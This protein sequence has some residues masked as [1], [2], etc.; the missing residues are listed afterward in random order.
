MKIFRIIG[1]QPY[2][3]QYHLLDGNGN[4]IDSHFSSSFDWAKR[5]MVGLKD[6]KNYE[7]VYGEFRVEILVEDTSKYDDL[8]KK[9]IK[10]RGCQQE[11]SEY[12]TD[13][14]KKHTPALNSP[15]II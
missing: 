10:K 1:S 15:L 14:L 9:Q 8:L 6:K 12:F 4:L 2:N 11:Y 5:D 13:K 3:C 7:K